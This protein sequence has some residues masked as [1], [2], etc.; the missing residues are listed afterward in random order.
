MRQTAVPAG[1]RLAVRPGVEIFSRGVQG[2][3]RDYFKN[4]QADQPERHMNSIASTLSPSVTS[5]IR[6][7]HTHVLSTFHQYKVD[8]SPV[9][10]QALVRTV[11]FL[12]EIHAQLEE[13]IFYPALQA[14]APDSGVV[15]KNVPEHDEMRHLIAEL[16]NMDPADPAYDQTFMDLMRDVIHHVGDEE[17]LQLPEAE[18]IMPER[19][20]ELGAQ[21]TK[22]RLELIVPRTGEVA[23]HSLRAVSTSAVVL[24]TGVLMAGSYLV[25]RAL[26]RHA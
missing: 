2:N 10:K 8:S 3:A 26:S 12:L 1:K 6:M 22:R 18:R 21:M 19:L 25:K 14:A 5:L 4:D 15:D 7:D 20:K 23:M 17:T 11:C 13:E 16:R 9:T 24:T